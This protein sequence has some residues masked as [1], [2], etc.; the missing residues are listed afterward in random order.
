MNKCKGC[1]DFINPR[2]CF[3][4]DMGNS[5]HVQ[6]CP[7]REC[8]IKVMCACACG[9]YSELSNKVEDHMVGNG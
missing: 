2:S 9:E 5:E 1:N 7:C 6:L 4:I 8:L 3:I